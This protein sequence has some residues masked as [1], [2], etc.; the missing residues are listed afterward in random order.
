MHSTIGTRRTAVQ[1]FK[2]L[3]RPDLSVSRPGQA[4]S[5]PVSNAAAAPCGAPVGAPSQALTV[6]ECS[7]GVAQIVHEERTSYTRQVG[8]TKRVCDQRA[9][10]LQGGPRR[11]GHAGV[12]IASGAQALCR[13]WRAAARGRAHSG[14]QPAPGALLR[15]PARAAVMFPGKQARA[16]AASRCPRKLVAAPHSSQL[17]CS[18]VCA[19]A[20]TGND[21]QRR[22]QPRYPPPRASTRR[23]CGSVVPP[24]CLLHASAVGV[25]LS[26]AG[27]EGG[28]GC[29]RPDPVWRS[30]GA[31]QVVAA[32][33]RSWPTWPGCA[34]ADEPA[35]PGTM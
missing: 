11:D 18:C 3:S 28:D 26:D 33:V 25:D 6:R 9:H 8:K 24:R 21:N 13:H 22:A 32:V 35:T 1:S 16:R 31:G 7:A 2:L 29:E 14:T 12:C 19:L 10:L 23:G 17:L 5:L 15:R 34:V 4:N 30:W 27:I 20:H